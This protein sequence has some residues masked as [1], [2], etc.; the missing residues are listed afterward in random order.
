M[1]Q[2][3]AKCMVCSLLLNSLSSW[4][5]LSGGTQGPQDN[6]SDCRSLCALVVG[7]WIWGMERAQKWKSRD[8]RGLSQ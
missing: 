6:G 7:P 2:I 1:P 8:Q 5:R 4:P 3:P